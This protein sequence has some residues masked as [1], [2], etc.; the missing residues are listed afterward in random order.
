MAC[1]C[2]CYLP[3]AG[4][5]DTTGRSQG[6][7]KHNL[8]YYYVCMIEEYGVVHVRHGGAAAGVGGFGGFDL[9]GPNGAFARRSDTAP[10][11][12]PGSSGLTQAT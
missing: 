5:T 1:S 3:H 4:P 7:N 11:G 12:A 10:A 8:M 2:A 6:A 9:V